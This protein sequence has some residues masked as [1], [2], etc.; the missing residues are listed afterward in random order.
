MFAH[1]RWFTV[2]HQHAEP[3][4]KVQTKGKER[5]HFRYDETTAP[6]S[7]FLDIA[8]NNGKVG[9]LA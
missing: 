6:L 3:Q 2:A 7:V 1:P 5:R 9:Q 8:G 4:V